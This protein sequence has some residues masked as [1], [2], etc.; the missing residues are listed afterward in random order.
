LIVHLIV[1]GRPIAT[2][3]KPPNNTLFDKLSAHS[4]S[5][6]SPLLQRRLEL[7]AKASVTN[8]AGTRSVS[9]SSGPEISDHDTH[10]HVISDW[11][12]E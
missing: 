4:L 5:A 3:D 7:N 1:E 2:L 8:T 6:R 10:E 11:I 12:S 9:R